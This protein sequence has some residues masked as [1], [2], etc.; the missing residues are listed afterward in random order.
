M[1]KQLYDLIKQLLS[2]A[3][4]TQQN[5]AEI[6]ELRQELKE[7]TAVV[8]RLAYE[9]HRV[10]ENEGHERE[11][12]ALRLENEL[13]KFERRLPSGNPKRKRRKLM[14]L[15]AHH[16]QL[17]KSTS[18]TVFTDCLVAAPAGPQR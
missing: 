15:D 8:Q 16:N 3:R 7:L 6:K 12:L 17:Q 1:F 9:I 13:L 11:K 10:S 2:L 14:Q 5:K 18:N 4:E